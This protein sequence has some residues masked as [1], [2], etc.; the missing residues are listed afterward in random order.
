LGICLI[1]GGFAVYFENSTPDD[2]ILV[3]KFWVVFGFVAVLTLIA[4]FG[5]LFGLKKDPETSVLVI[6]GALVVKLLFSM[7]FVLV[8]LLKFKVKGVDFCIQFFSLYFLF[9]AFEVYALLCNLRHQNK[10]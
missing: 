1:S 8:Y 3:P 10:T 6:M 5:S 2:T 7:A 4:Y 9:T